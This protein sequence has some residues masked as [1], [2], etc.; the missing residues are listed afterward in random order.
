MTYRIYLLGDIHT[1][2]RPWWWRQVLCWYTDFCHRK[3]WSRWFCKNWDLS[4]LPRKILISPSSGMRHRIWL[5]GYQIFGEPPC[6]LLKL[7]RQSYQVAPKSFFSYAKRHGVTSQKSVIWFRF[8]FVECI[9]YYND[10]LQPEPSLF[11]SLREFWGGGM[12]ELVQTDCA[13][14][15]IDTGV[16]RPEREADYAFPSSF[17]IKNA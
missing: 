5:P 6:L 11:D 14:R 9:R 4:F 15:L 3:F 17:E 2:T 10:W 1:S 12:L 7:W 8:I 13:S 16:K